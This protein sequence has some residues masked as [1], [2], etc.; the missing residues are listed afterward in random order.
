M[1]LGEIRDFKPRDSDMYSVMDVMSAKYGED[2]REYIETMDY[3]DKIC[4]HAIS[5]CTYDNLMA[6][7]KLLLETPVYRGGGNTKQGGRGGTRKFPEPMTVLRKFAYLSSAI[8]HMVK[9]GIHLDNNC[10]KVV[11]YLRELDKQ[12]KAKDKKK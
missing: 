12:K 3:F 6:H 1:V 11:A 8:N 4:G 2:G 5:W 9:Q 7:A 10:L